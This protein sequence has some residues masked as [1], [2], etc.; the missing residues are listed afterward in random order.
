MSRKIILGGGLMSLAI[1]ALHVFGGGPEFH[2]PALQSPLEPAW[3]AGFST[4]WHQ[5]TAFLV[6]NGVFLIAA[7]RAAQFNRELVFLIILQ[8]TAFGLLF[9]TYGWVRLGNPFILLQWILF[10]PLAFLLWLG[11]LRDSSGKPN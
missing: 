1:A 10:L 9:L 5:V 8:N 11:L 3:K 6:L 7:S 4:I 2:V